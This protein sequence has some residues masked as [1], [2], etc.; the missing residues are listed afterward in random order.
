MSKKAGIVTIVLLC[1][2]SLTLLT[3]NLSLALMAD[4]SDKTGI[5][6]FKQ[7]KLDI[8]I[9][10]ADSIVLS[11]EELTIG[12]L[13]TRKIN[14]TNPQ[15]STSCAFRIWLEFYV[16]GNLDNNYLALSLDETKFKQSESGKWYYNNVLA[17]GASLSNLVLTFKVNEVESEEYQGKKYSI[18]LFV[19]STQSTKIAVSEWQDDYSVE[20]FEGI[21]NNLF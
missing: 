20:W 19:E 21:K 2:L 11:K 16:D 10:D 6:Q 1:V 18:K 14:I 9:V 8:E 3:L 5:I 13:A 7:H 15:N 4:R 12:S 17:S